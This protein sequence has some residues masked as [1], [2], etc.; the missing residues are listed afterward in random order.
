MVLQT[1]RRVDQTHPRLH[2]MQARRLWDV[3]FAVPIIL[4]FFLPKVLVMQIGFSINEFLAVATLVTGTCWVTWKIKVRRWG[5]VPEKKPLW[6]SF[7]AELFVVV[8]LMFTCRVAVADWPKVPSGSMEPTLRVGDYLLVNHL[9]YGPRLPFTNTAI[10]W[11]QP[12]R[13]DVVV[14]RFPLDASEF[15][16]KRLVGMPGDAVRFQGGAVTVNNTAFDVQLLSQGTTDT[17]APED[18]GQWLLRETAAG[19]SRTIKV[20]PF[21]MGRLRTDGMAEH[22]TEQG[23]N[24]WTCWVP[25][26]QYLMMGDNRD[27]SADSRVWGF[28]PHSQVYG[29]AVRV[30]F[31]LNDLSRAWTP[32]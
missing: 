1:G 17:A 16:V 13:G 25:D 24:A 32:L 23:D 30:L 28:L 31:N 27:N 26:G 20:N 12:R 5:A 7:G 19:N 21:V 11:G 18:R 9:A 4:R 29:K 2:R 6:V 10:E 8:A 22:C 15:Y 14:F 3:A